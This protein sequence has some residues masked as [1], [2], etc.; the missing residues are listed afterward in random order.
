MIRMK[1]NFIDAEVSMSEVSWYQTGGKGLL[2]R[3]HNTDELIDLIAAYQIKGYEVHVIGE[4][5]NIL[6]LEDLSEKVFLQTSGMASLVAD[7]SNVTAS[8]GCSLQDL[9]DL[10]IENGMGKVAVMSGIPGSVGG[11]VHMNA[12]AFG[13]EIFDFVNSITFFD[14][15]DLTLRTVKAIDVDY[16]Y[17]TSGWLARKI[18]TAVEVD[19]VRDEVDGKLV[20]ETTINRRKQKQPLKYR[21]CGSVFKR[22][23]NGFAGSLIEQCGLKGREIGR[24]RISKKHGNF[25]LNYGGCQGSDVLD[26]I[27]LCES[28]VYQQTGISLQRE[29]RVIGKSER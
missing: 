12:G 20:R 26:L 9:L 4:T 11:A 8:A 15:T 25:I 29:V 24:A 5:T 19:L 3:P 17:R 21:S 18:I 13:L 22:P 10:L 14:P 7:G 23:V 1:S 6:F 16:G 28:T 2:I 27:E